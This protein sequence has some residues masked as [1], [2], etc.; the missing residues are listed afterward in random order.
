MVS[1]LSFA[2]GESFANGAIEYLYQPATPGEATPRI[3]L[4][5]EVE[6]IVVPAVVDTGAPYVICAPRLAGTTALRSA[7]PLQRE[8]ILIRGS[9]ITGN[10]YRLGLK[11]PAELGEE[12]ELEATAFVPDREWEDAWGDL[13]S[14][15]GMGGCLERIRFAI[16]PGSDTFYFGLLT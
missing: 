5:V 11:F 12:L 7:T 1:L 16:D 6:G 13:P 15:I 14:F 8:T 9:W 4:P 2:D 3:I 10:L